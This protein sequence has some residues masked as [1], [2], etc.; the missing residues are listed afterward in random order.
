[1]RAFLIVFILFVFFACKK[2]E[3]RKC[4]K[5]AGEYS[6]KEITLENFSKLNLGP[7][8][9]FT[10]VQDTVNKM[11]VSGPKNLLNFVTS[12]INSEGE[13]KIYNKN[14][15][16]FL[17]SYSKYVKVKIHLKKITEIFSKISKDLTCLNTLQT[18]SLNIHI[19]EGSGLL[20]INVDAN[21]FSLRGNG[22]CQIQLD[23]N[24]NYARFEIWDNFRL[25][26]ANLTAKDQLTIK[27]HSS[28]NAHVYADNCK[29]GAQISSDGS[30]WYKGTPTSIEYLRY[31]TGKLTNKN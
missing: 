8:I 26:A 22:H 6:S 13:L 30:V 10:L 20:S 7:H 9:E 14:K 12:E 1:M 3:D 21:N 16:N 2:A 19:P 17:R 18:S 25:N 29:L 15:C 27:S 31:G 24:V 23:G 5:S 4:V 11:I 28:A